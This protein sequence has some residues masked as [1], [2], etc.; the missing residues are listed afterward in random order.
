MTQKTYPPD[1][2]DHRDVE[3]YTYDANGNR[4]TKTVG[5]VTT[6]YTYDA[7]NRVLSETP[8]GTGAGT[9]SIHYTY[10]GGGGRLSKKEIKRGTDVVRSIAFTYDA[11]GRI[12][13][14][15]TP[16]G[17][18][19]FP[20]TLAFGYDAAGNRTSVTAPAP[21]GT[22]TTDYDELNRPKDVHVPGVS[23]TVHVSYDPNGNRESIAYPNGVTTSY[24]YNEQNRLTLLEHA[25]ASSTLAAYSYT[26][27][28]SGN[29][30][31]V[32]EQPSGRTIHWDYDDLYRLTGEAIT[33]SVNGNRTQGFTYD[34]VGNRLE[35]TDSTL[36]GP[37]TYAY[38]NADHLTSITPDGEAETLQ[39]WDES[40]RLTLRGATPLVWNPW[41]RLVKKD[42]GSQTQFAY[43]PDG[44]VRTKQWVTSSPTTTQKR[45]YVYDR[46]LP[47]AQVLQEWDNVG[48]AV[49]ADYLYL[50]GDLIGFKDERSGVAARYWVL[51]DG[52]NSVRKVVDASASVVASYDYDAFG[53]TLA[54]TQPSGWIFNHRA[55]GEVFDPQ[56][57][58]GYHRAR[59]LDNATGRFTARDPW[60]G[61]VGDPRSLHRYAY[62]SNNPLN[63]FDPSGLIEIGVGINITRVDL[64][65]TVSGVNIGLTNTSGPNLPTHATIDHLDYRP[66]PLDDHCD[67]HPYTNT[68]IV[69]YFY[70]SVDDRIV[71]FDGDVREEFT[72]EKTNIAAQFQV[73]ETS[74]WTM[75]NNVSL[76]DELAVY[77]DC[78][79]ATFWGCRIPTSDGK[80]PWQVKYQNWILRDV[81]DRSKVAIFRV[82]LVWEEEDIRA[83]PLKKG[84]SFAEDPTQYL[85]PGYASRSP[86]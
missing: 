24:Q 26:L 59:W 21:Y 1:A 86:R 79:P 48:N 41:D 34:D 71:I 23:G 80:A 72:S 81:R 62:V 29:R 75:Q 28:P 38:D 84:E 68:R 52:Q 9:E 5:G 40:G 6:T 74:N 85:S 17:A 44:I 14:Q 16:E 83:I 43:S 70:K 3:T 51:K 65:G 30:T 11:R 39:S 18:G 54:Q 7:M 4:L 32:E 57:E 78:D 31:D 36:S 56:L 27:G 35:R 69:T 15:S 22:V 67:L 45:R 58:M 10:Q 76:Q 33:D 50:D 77:W 47:Y 37:T 42:D 61:T 25:T 64:V 8:S 12:Q 55:F 73:R 66:G 46:T 2:N 49:M 13:T 63:R 19:A 82:V 20:D 53:N 60:E